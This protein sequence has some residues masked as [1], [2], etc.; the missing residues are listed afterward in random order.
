[1]SRWTEFG[2][3]YFPKMVNTISP[4]KY[5]ILQCDFA[6]SHREVK[7]YYPTWTWPQWLAWPKEGGRVTLWDIWN[8]IICLIAS[9]WTSEQVTLGL[10]PLQTA[11]MLRALSHLQRPWVGAPEGRPSNTLSSQHQLPAVWHPNSTEPSDKRSL[12]LCWTSI[13]WKTSS[14]VQSTY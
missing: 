11:A 10:L 9:S 8:R 13:V 7:S 14:W 1:M 4:I 2:R 3:L 6:I 12:S 5:A